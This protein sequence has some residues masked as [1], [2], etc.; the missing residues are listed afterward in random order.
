MVGVVFGSYLVGI[1]SFVFSGQCCL[2]CVKVLVC[3]VVLLFVLLSIFSF[4]LFRT[5][6]AAL[7]Y[8]HVERLSKHLRQFVF[9]F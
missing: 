4:Y 8:L 5:R 6:S 3:V 1:V 7:D 9:K 2:V